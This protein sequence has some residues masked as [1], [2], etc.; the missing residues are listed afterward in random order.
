MKKLYIVN[1]K[2]HVIADPA[3]TAADLRDEW[4]SLQDMGTDLTDLLGRCIT[5][6]SKHLGID[7][8]EVQK[9]LDDCVNDVWIDLYERFSD[10]TKL[11]KQLQDRVTRGKDSVTLATP[12]CKSAKAVLMRDIRERDKLWDTD[13]IDEMLDAGF[14]G[15]LPAEDVFDDFFFT[16]LSVDAIIEECPELR[17]KIWRMIRDGYPAPEIAKETGVSQDTVH[18][19]KKKFRQAAR[20]LFF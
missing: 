17:Q 20:D 18:R 11:T 8:A 14:T 19:E 13:S 16:S 15:T 7:P 10:L 2:K 5:K 3:I 6:V 4:E 9:E 12:I 1:L